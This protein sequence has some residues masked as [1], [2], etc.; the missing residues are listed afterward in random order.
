MLYPLYCESTFQA[1]AAGGYHSSLDD[2][3]NRNLDPHTY[4][5][6][7]GPC[8]VLLT[9]TLLESFV[10]GLLND[11]QRRGVIAFLRWCAIC[12]LCSGCVHD[13][14]CTV[15]DAAKKQVP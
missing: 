9:P 6:V 3:W 13:A 5:D 2:A 10:S 7:G 12:R 15:R 8:Q 11:Q 4:A 14:R 1:R